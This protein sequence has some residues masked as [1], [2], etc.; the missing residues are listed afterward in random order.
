MIF[1]LHIYQIFIKISY[2]NKINPFFT[3]HYFTFTHN[4]IYRKPLSLWR[5]VLVK[6]M[7]LFLLLSNEIIR[8]FIMHMK[9]Y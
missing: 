5:F 8:I 3:V 6:F 4:A 9:V 2:H 7:H 1:L